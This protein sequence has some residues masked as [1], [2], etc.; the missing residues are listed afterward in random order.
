MVKLE[1]GGHTSSSSSS[2]SGG[3]GGDKGMA[4]VT[5]VVAAT[6]TVLPNRETWDGSTALLVGAGNATTGSGSGSGIREMGF[7]GTGT[8]TG[9]PAGDEAALDQNLGHRV[10]PGTIAGVVI[11]TMLGLRVIMGGMAFWFVRKRGKRGG[12]GV[13]GAGNAVGKGREGDVMEML[14]GGRGY[15]KNA[16][17]KRWAKTG[18]SSVVEPQELEGGDLEASLRFEL[19]AS[20]QRRLCTANPCN[21]PDA[22][23]TKA[24]A[25]PWVI[26][27]SVLSVLVAIALL[28]STVSWFRRRRRRQLELRTTTAADPSE[29]S[30]EYDSSK[31]PKTAWER[32]Q[33]HSDCLPRPDPQELESETAVFGPASPPQE[34]DGTTKLFR[35]PYPPRELDA[36]S[37]LVADYCELGA[38]AYRGRDVKIDNEDGSV[39]VTK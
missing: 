13:A 4:V 37:S 32:S 19:D 15:K 33:L 8:P 27:A 10:R 9:G 29:P 38:G 39:E 36:T 3:G 18:I 23:A 1:G 7:Q 31:E 11:G 2:S 6:L 30:Q 26:L 34:L 5:A 14:G 21:N 24:L 17:R 28:G 12:S 22:A 20:S 16:E 35:P 25:T